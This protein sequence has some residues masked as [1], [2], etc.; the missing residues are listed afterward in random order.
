ME[1]KNSITH[2]RAYSKINIFIFSRTLF[3]CDWGSILVAKGVDC[4]AVRF[5]VQFKY[6]VDKTFPLVKPKKSITAKGP[7]ADY[8]ACAVRLK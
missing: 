4:A 6:L 5:T 3:L 8:G 7:L 1:L 2:P